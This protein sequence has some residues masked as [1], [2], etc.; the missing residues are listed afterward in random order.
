MAKA[1][2]PSDQPLVAASSFVGSVD[3]KE[4]WFREGEAVAQDH[5]AVKKWPQLFRI[6]TFR[7]DEPTRIEAATAA[8]GE[9]R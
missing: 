3:G 1:A 6:Q 2:T 7:H 8:P 9:V 5:P 4:Y